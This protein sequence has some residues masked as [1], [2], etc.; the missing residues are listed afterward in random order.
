MNYFFRTNNTQRTRGPKQM[1]VTYGFIGLGAMGYPMALNL[2]QKTSLETKLYVY[3]VHKPSCE[4]FV[5]ET[6]ANGPV[7]I[8]NSAKELADV[9]DVVISIIPTAADVRS[10]YLDTSEGIL[11]AKKNSGRLMLECST[12]DSQTA[13]EVGQT[14]KDASSG[15]YIDTPVSVRSYTS[16]DT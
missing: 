13:C 3:D 8:A 11:A 4:K 6:K 7:H 1:A 5:A 15:T 12:I 16:I 14:L 10:V 2:R 9:S